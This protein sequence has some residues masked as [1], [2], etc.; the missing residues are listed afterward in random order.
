M[1]I[2]D[3]IQVLVLT[4]PFSQLQI[5][6]FNQG[7]RMASFL[8]E[9]RL[10][11]YTEDPMHPLKVDVGYCDV[12]ED[13]CGQSEPVSWSPLFVHGPVSLSLQRVSSG[14]FPREVKVT[15]VFSPQC[16]F[17]PQPPSLHLLT[18]SPPH[19]GST[20][21]HPLLSP[22]RFLLPTYTIEADGGLRPEQP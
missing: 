19:P 4:K 15:G 9:V 10:S 17:S 5:P 11:G 13:N 14:P 6:F 1:D 21:P 3:G 22:F 16:P 8:H 12:R 20:F 18:S 2:R 7:T